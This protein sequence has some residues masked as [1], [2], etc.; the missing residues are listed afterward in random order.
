MVSTIEYV[1]YI[2]IQYSSDERKREHQPNVLVHEA[3]K[4][5]NSKITITLF[6]PTC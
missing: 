4:R 6:A 2:V 5:S 1:L 3:F